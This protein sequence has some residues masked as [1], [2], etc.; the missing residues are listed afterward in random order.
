MFYEWVTAGAIF[1]IEAFSAI[2]TFFLCVAALYS[3][4][5]VMFAVARAVSGEGGNKDDMDRG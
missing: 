3:I 2:C 4:C 1:G 5:A